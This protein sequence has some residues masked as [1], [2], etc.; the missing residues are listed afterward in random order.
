MFRSKQVNIERE[1]RSV[2]TKH[3]TRLLAKI[4]DIALTSCE[5]SFPNIERDK[6][7][8]CENSREKRFA[9]MQQCSLQQC[10]IA[11]PIIVNFDSYEQMVLL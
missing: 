5:I 7:P 2:R 4:A 10:Y 9:A 11:A 1:L 3:I 8:A 6:G